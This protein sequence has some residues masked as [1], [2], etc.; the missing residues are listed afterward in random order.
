MSTNR[1]HRLRELFEAAS[2]LAPS[3]RPAFLAEACGDSEDLLLEVQSLLSLDRTGNP[4]LEGDWP[5]LLAEGALV[6]PYRVV[7]EIGRGGMGIVYLAQDTRL[8]RRVALKALRPGLQAVEKQRERFRREAGMAAGL[9]HPGI[10][11]IYALEEWESGQYIVSEYIEGVT[12]ADELERGAVSLEAV[13]DIGMQVSAAVAAAHEKGVVH[14]DLKPQNIIRGTDGRLKI[15]DFGLAIVCEPDGGAHSRL[16]EAGALLG[17]PGYMAPEQLR[18][19]AADYRSDLFALGIVLATAASG[20]HPFAGSTAAVTLAAIFASEPLGLDHL[21]KASPR[22]EAV[23]RRCL[24]KDSAQ[25]FQSAVELHQ[26]LEQVQ[27]AGLDAPPEALPASAVGQLG[28]RWWVG[29]QIG[30]VAACVLLTAALWQVS[31]W[32][33][34]RVTLFT[35]IGGLAVASVIVTLRLHLIF[36]YRR[37]R[38]AIFRELTG[39]TPWARRADWSFSLLLAVAGVDIAGER[40]LV[41]ALLL[42]FAAAYAIVFLFA[43]PSTRSSAFD[44]DSSG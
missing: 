15:L 30:I 17:T 42:G 36:T 39:V 9:S 10:A 19:E 3:A 38:S 1:F 26:A 27:A 7:R 24:N 18:G 5:E 34:D 41:A 28:M 32:V 8:D 20:R 16:T 44:D 33:P 21:Q 13:L 4:F 6:G 43:E 23:I 11:T 35:F 12:L 25:R 40:R 31:V 2:E 37:N 22:L 14:R 29:H